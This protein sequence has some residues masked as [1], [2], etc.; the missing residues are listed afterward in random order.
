MIRLFVGRVIF[1]RSIRLL[2]SSSGYD[3]QHMEKMIEMMDRRPPI[4][5]NSEKTPN[6]QALK[7][8]ISPPVPL[9]P[10]ELGDCPGV[11]FNEGAPPVVSVSSSSGSFRVHSRLAENIFKIGQ[12][13]S[14]YVSPSFVSVTKEKDAK[15]TELR[16]LIFESL[17][18]H[19]APPDSDG[20]FAARSLSPLT[21]V[22]ILARSESG[23][24]STSGDAME[25]T[26]GDSEVVCTIKELM[27][28]RIR[29]A[30][31]EDGGDIRYV[32]FDEVTGLVSVQLAGSCVGCPSSSV[33]LRQG[34]ENMLMH[35]IPEVKG[36]L[37]VPLEAVVDEG[38]AV[39]TWTD[40]T[41]S[42]KFDPETK[43]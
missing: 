26:E 25:I 10:S 7:F 1:P 18:N 31:Q 6:P 29:P 16:P 19:F 40:E 27:Q 41:R 11:T 2:S 12:I 33:T 22:D 42:L 43:P 9:F 36:I 28:T 39:D 35:Y 34:V 4:N 37:E 13:S 15:W 30:V 24:S 17:L 8:S 23:Q 21:A 5:I 38:S 20:P 3:L 32:G 14:V